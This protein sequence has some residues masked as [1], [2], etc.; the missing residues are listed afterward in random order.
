MV[1]SDTNKP[2]NRNLGDEAERLNLAT[3]NKNPKYDPNKILHMNISKLKE[4]H[5]DDIRKQLKLS[6]VIIIGYEDLIESPDKLKIVKSG[7]KFESSTK[8]G[9]IMYNILNNKEELM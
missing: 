6:G 9:K 8:L 1:T 2:D 3:F 7:N 5:A 4:K